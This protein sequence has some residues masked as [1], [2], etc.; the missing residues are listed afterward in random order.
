MTLADDDVM[1]APPS[2]S[3]V[4]LTSDPGRDAIYVLGDEIVA[5]VR[6]DRSVTVTGPPQLGL[7]MGGGTRPMTHRG[8]GGEVLTFAY[9]V[10]DGD[11]DTDGVG[12][13][14]GSLSGAIRDSAG[15]AASLDHAAVEAD[16]GHRVDGVRP[17]L[18]QAV[19]DG[20][21]LTLRYDEVLRES[22][23]VDARVL[24]AFA[25]KSGGDAVH[26]DHVAVT[27]RTVRLELSRWVL[28]GETVT[29][30]YRP[31]AWS[32]RDAA[33]TGAAA[34]SD[35]PATNEAPEPHYDADRNGLIEITTLAQLDAVRHDLD[36]DGRPRGTGGA[37]AYRAA[38]P[39]AFADGQARL[40]CHGA[41]IGY[42]LLA[43]L[44]F[45]D[46][47][48]DGRVDADDDADG[49]GQVA[50][51]DTAWWN[52]GS[53][54]DPI[55]GVFEA[56]FDG[57]RHA[58]RH[59]FIDRPR[60]DDVGLFGV[61]GSGSSIRDVAVIGIDVT[62]GARVG[63]LVGDNSGSVR[64]AQ[65]TGRVSGEELVGGLVGSN[66]GPIAASYAT[67]R[68]SGATKVGGLVG[69]NVGLIGENGLIGDIGFRGS[70]MVSYATGAVSG[71]TKV[72]GLV[73]E[74]WPLSSITA[75]YATGA[76]SGATKVG[77]L[78]GE[79]RFLGQV[80]ASYA[81]GPVSGEEEV[82]G[83]VG[84]SVSA[85]IGASYW[86]TTTSGRATSGG[87]RGHGTTTLQAPTGY[88]GLYADWDL[89][90]NRNGSADNPWRFGTDAQ[91]PAL[92]V[93][94][95]G[96]G[97][98]TWEEFGHQ[99]R[100][101]PVATASSP[102]GGAPV[103]LTWTAVDTSRWTP[104]PV[105][106]A[107][108]R[109]A[110]GTV[111][112]LASGLDVR[113]YRDTTVGAGAAPAYQVAA[114][115]SGGEAARSGWA[116]VTVRTP[117]NR[118]PEAVGALGALTLR[119]ADGA[120]TVDVSGAFLDPDGDPLTYAA[121]SPAPGVAAVEM[122]KIGGSAGARGLARSTV[123][124]TPLAA[125]ETTVTVTATDAGGSGG[126]AA[127]SFR[128]TVP[129]EDVDVDY[130][131]DDDGL[132]E[133]ATL[134]QLDAVRHDLDGDGIPAG[135][136]APPTAGTG[137]ASGAAAGSGAAAT[138]TAAAAGSGTTVAGSGAAAAA[139]SGEAPAPGAAAHAAAFPDAAE[140]MGCPAP[141]CVG[142]ELAADLDFDT[143]GSG[144]ADAG[145]AFWNGGAG[146]RP[147][148]TFDEP[149]TAVFSG[150]GRTV[151]HLFVGGGDNAG[152]FGLSS[153]VIRGVGVVAA[154]VTGSR[155]AGALAGLN[156]GWVEASWST[157][158]V[159]GESCVGGLVGVNGL[160]VPDGGTF[161][162][163]EG[164]VTA[165]WSSADVTAE[166]W[167]GGLVGYDNGTVAASY[168][169]G[170]VTATTEG[171]GAGGLV[172]RMG[173]GGN[174]ITAS[175][176]TGAVSGPGGAVGGLVGHAMPH[177]RVEASYWDTETSGVTR[178]GGGDGRT[179]AA[180]QEP[181]GYTGPY[182][183]WD[184]DVDGDGVPDAPW[185]FGT[186]GAYPAL[187]VDADGDGA[188]TWR[189][190][191]SQGRAG[192]P[193]AGAGASSGSAAMRVQAG[194][195]AAPASGAGASGGRAAPAA[196][197]DDPLVPGVTPVRAV[198]LLELRSRIDGLRLRA[199]L[200]AFGWTDAQVVPGATPARAVHLLELRSALGE[201]YAAAARAAPGY[202]D[203]VVTPGATAMRARQLQELRRA[204]VA[205][206]AA[207][208]PT[209]P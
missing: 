41:C 1:A 111:E 12:I 91:Y 170:A 124:V 85:G 13:A 151:S 202:T 84:R 133:I 21:R 45:L 6:F 51:D 20:R 50:A 122:A 67:A 82:G 142:Y 106:W 204:V 75:S 114:E 123:T 168:A 19:A 16:A 177:D 179:T 22:A 64:A 166:Q 171:S 200:P 184:V 70:I 183:A 180:L 39:L 56:A 89:D 115:V 54:W 24:A 52:G 96:D 139:G 156:G 14:A 194:D 164:F 57:N 27:S 102:D 157:G 95:D 83:L 74:N 186:P 59:L 5:T 23:G 132:I 117:P 160:W 8:G 185:D 144:A 104:P 29:V 43:D 167:V 173:F 120:A 47:D 206:E 128:V 137:A 107:V 126:T 15:R 165:S 190:L 143:D 162:P 31:G 17:V 97:Q 145:D 208:A 150:N 118:R 178:G 81:T 152:L 198:H 134:A 192:P 127:Q 92:A 116:P 155:C 73:G 108:Y 138:G 76:V 69:E 140:R 100:A 199:G 26:V 188:A 3:A 174:R 18:Q 11:S 159:T 147:L 197:T 66:A 193:P 112:R 10:T 163:L 172:G 32:I 141:A 42:E 158:A 181:T 36:G 169:T 53:G 201:A 80:A 146:W 98:A 62:G 195:A 68:V 113:V 93:D 28:H 161:R 189:E 48:G 94:F 125:G 60:A 37:A 58:V 79:N 153:G 136:G 33:G 209:G 154:D 63:G 207:P 71:A 30:S 131:A 130:D 9:T 121:S 61:A 78:V 90:L 205:L 87:G 55:G 191:G 46:V 40:G 105:T 35:R 25:V 65:A 38:F 175:Y 110:G 119:I 4:A 44:D 86:D 196:F 72:G 182:A 88:S 187:S 77:G 109:A 101:G 99:V 176:A 49:D 7:T 148:G 135:S 2:V 129:E 34:F 149:F 203:A 103:T